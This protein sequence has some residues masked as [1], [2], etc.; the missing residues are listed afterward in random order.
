MKNQI[1]LTIKGNNQFTDFQNSSIQTL[2]A[3]IKPQTPAMSQTSDFISYKL[4][5]FQNT[6]QLHYFSENVKDR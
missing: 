1:I 3:I 2:T 4:S 6:L 5:L